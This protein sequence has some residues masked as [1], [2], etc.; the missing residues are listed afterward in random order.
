MAGNVT[1][2]R[3]HGEGRGGRNV[4]GVHGSVTGKRTKVKL[5]AWKCNK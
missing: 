2:A 1:K 5:G 3:S 4:T